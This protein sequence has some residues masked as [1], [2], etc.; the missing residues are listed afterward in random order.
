[1]DKVDF[2]EDFESFKRE[3]GTR[4]FDVEE[5]VDSLLKLAARWDELGKRVLDGRISVSSLPEESRIEGEVLG[6]KFCI[7]YAPFGL[8]GDGALELALS[9]RDLVTG[10]SVE[11]NRFLLSSGGS[12][13]ALD[14]GL[15]LNMDYRDSAKQALIAITRRVLSAPSKS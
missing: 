3:I 7:A 2:A 12:I 13:Y 8:S 11:L 5:A 1:M 14:G 15:L 10:E 6:K 4:K 9:I